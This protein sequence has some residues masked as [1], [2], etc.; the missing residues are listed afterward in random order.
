M[1]TQPQSTKDVDMISHDWHRGPVL[2]PAAPRGNVLHEGC[3]RM[4]KLSRHLVAA[5]GSAALV[6][7]LAT[8]VFAQGARPA[9]PAG[10]PG[11]GAVGRITGTVTDK[12]KNPISFANVIVLGTKQGTMTDEKGTYMIV[13]VPVGT[14]Q[15]QVQATGYDKVV[16]P[17]EVNAGAT[18][19]TNLVVGEAKVTKQFEEIEVRAEK[20]IDTKSSTTKQTITA[21]KLREIP[22]D[23]LREAVAVKAG[24]VAMG[25][26][27]H[28]RGGRSGEVKTTF[29]G[30]EVTD[31][32]FGR[33]ANIANLAVAGAEVL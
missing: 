24:V 31:P 18:T 26:E 25:G 11:A 33:G 3:C 1:S 2:P 28:F 22:V 10:S 8:P 13:G 19:T 17:V 29:D 30:V 12:S 5:A 27:L 15:L 32:L 14:V 16:Q 23:N 4:S 20:R 6:L 7:A 21:E 9:A